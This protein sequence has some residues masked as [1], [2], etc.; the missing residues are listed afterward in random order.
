MHIVEQNNALKM[1][2]YTN[3]KKLSLLNS[4]ATNQN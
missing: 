3:F 4:L 1:L 2:P